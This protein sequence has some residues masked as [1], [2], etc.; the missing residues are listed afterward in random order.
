VDRLALVSA[1]KAPLGNP[2]VPP[3]LYESARFHRGDGPA[4]SALFVVSS[5]RCTTRD[6]PV[7]HEAF[8]P[9]LY[10]LNASGQQGTETASPNLPKSHEQDDAHGRDWNVRFRRDPH[11]LTWDHGPR[12][13]RAIPHP[14]ALGWGVPGGIDSTW[15]RAK[16]NA[17]PVRY[18]TRTAR[19]IGIRAS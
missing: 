11:S 12:P 7:P 18:R 3:N 8:Q 17:V 9:G 16:E 15:K 13:R 14:M 1:R 10:P 5:P 4:R 19:G 6:R 2:A